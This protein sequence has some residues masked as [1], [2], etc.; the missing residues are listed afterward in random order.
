MN[1]KKLII[2]SI[3]AALLSGCC[4]Y[5][6]EWRPETVNK[7]SVGKVSK[8]TVTTAHKYRITGIKMD[9]ADFGTY[10]FEPNELAA[11]MPGVYSAS[12][13]AL[14][15]KVE[16]H[17]STLDMFTALAVLGYSS[18]KTITPCTLT[19]G[20]KYNASINFSHSMSMKMR[21]VLLSF[22]PFSDSEDTEY[23][24]KGFWERPENIP[25]EKT[26]SNVQKT[27]ALSIALALQEMEN[28]GLIA[29]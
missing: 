18:V 29:K 17:K 23:F 20:G 25:Q 1:S 5:L 24:C 19:V 15:V 9:G 8:D 3:T 7:R 12:V 2:G 6:N 14:P 13:D 4:T 27:V 26:Y 22:F 10:L 28:T 11:F 21:M 16:L